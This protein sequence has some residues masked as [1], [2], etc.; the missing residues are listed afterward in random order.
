ML[1]VDEV[2]TSIH[3]KISKSENVFE[4]FREIYP[5]LTMRLDRNEAMDEKGMRT[6]GFFYLMFRFNATFKGL[7][8]VLSSLLMKDFGY[9]E[10]ASAILLRAS[11]LDS[12]YVFAL[13][14]DREL[15]KCF[16]ADG[17]SQMV[18]NKVWNFSDEFKSQLQH[19]EKFFKS[20]CESKTGT[21]HLVTL[22]DSN[23]AKMCYYQYDV[24]SKYD[25]FGIAKF[26]LFPFPP[27]EQ[28]QNIDNSLFYMGVAMKT[29]IEIM[30]PDPN[31][32]IL[33]LNTLLDFHK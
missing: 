26:T 9:A 11:L 20:D 30:E 5:D 19:D 24:Y 23:I 27:K 13:E 7:G 10:H 21:G 32:K 22:A 12:I 8:K 15:I 25:H 29:L 31:N 2:L 18:K 1:L 6:F 33:L 14:K 28:L 17:Y 3:S 4:T 16:M